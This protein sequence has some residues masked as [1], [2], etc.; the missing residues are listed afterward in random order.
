MSALRV[1]VPGGDG[2][3]IRLR[4]VDVAKLRAVTSLADDMTEPDRDA[5]S[6]SDERTWSVVVHA[7]A[8]LGVLVPIIGGIL[9]PFLV[10]ILKKPESTV[11]D[12]HGKAAINFQISMLIYGIAG[13]LLIRAGV[14]LLILIVLAVF[15]FVM[16]LVATI[17]TA[18]GRDP[19][20]VFS[21]SF[22]K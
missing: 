20:Y 21:I 4:S 13:A 12:R 6:S 8:F 11:V 3:T 9:G 22:L 16:I 10:W 7:A 2:S 18:K 1:G 19:G 15:W 17:R 14:G 5:M